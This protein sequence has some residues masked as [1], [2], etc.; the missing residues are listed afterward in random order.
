MVLSKHVPQV[1]SGYMQMDRF[2]HLPLICVLHVRNAAHF[3]MPLG[4]L[5]H[6]PQKE[7]PAHY[8]LNISCIQAVAT[9]FVPSTIVVPPDVLPSLGQVHEE[10]LC[11]VFGLFYLVLF[12]L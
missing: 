9:D 4:F 6:V 1:R 7:Q 11:L 2:Q 8:Q 10:F 3:R 12:I 5:E